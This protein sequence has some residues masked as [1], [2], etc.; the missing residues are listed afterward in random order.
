MLTATNKT[1]RGAIRWHHASPL[2]PAGGIS[3]NAHDAH[4]VRATS[5]RRV[6]CANIPITLSCEA[7]GTTH[8]EHFTTQAFNP[9][10]HPE[11]A[12]TGNEGVAGTGRPISNDYEPGNSDESDYDNAE[13]A[14]EEQISDDMQQYSDKAAADD[15]QEGFEEEASDDIQE[16]ADEPGSG[17][18]QDHGHAL[19]DVVAKARAKLERNSMMEELTKG[20]AA[21]LHLLFDGRYTGD[22]A[23]PI[24][25]M[26]LQLPPEHAAGGIS[27]TVAA[28]AALGWPTVQ[29]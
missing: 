28:S 1:S 2:A 7:H 14:P 23:Q 29:N 10:D 12:F 6:G 21:Y 16:Y 19:Q 25:D 11:H 3:S 17:D 8:L 13:G 9:T 5:T 20:A 18:A 26:L 22:I 4:T 15:I 24:A 27:T